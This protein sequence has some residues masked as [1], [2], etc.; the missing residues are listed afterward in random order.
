M[1]HAPPVLAFVCLMIPSL[2]SPIRFLAKP[3]TLTR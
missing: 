1:S 2:S 3:Q